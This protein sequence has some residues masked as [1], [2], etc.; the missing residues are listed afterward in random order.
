MNDRSGMVVL[1]VAL[2][3]LLL[4][5][6]MGFL[7]LVGGSSPDCEASLAARNLGAIPDSAAG[8]DREQLTNAGEIIRAG[9]AEG[10]SSRDQTIG[11]MTAIGE[12]TLRVL[13]RG[14]A[15]GPDSRGL[16]QQRDNGAWGSYE[17]RMDPFLSARYFFRALQTVSGRSTMAPTLVAHRVQRNADPQHYALFWNQ[18]QQVF[19]ALTGNA[20][21]PG[22][23][24][25]AGG[26]SSRYKLGPVKHHVAVA[27][28]HIGRM[29]D[30][31]TIG[32]W[33]PGDTYDTEGHPAGLALDLIINSQE[34]GSRI[35]TYAREHAAEMGVKY[36]I[37]YQKIWSPQRDSE[38]WRYM[39]DRGSPSANHLDHVH[40]SFEAEPG[41][42]PLPEGGVPIPEG[43]GD[44]VVIDGQAAAATRGQWVQ[45]APGPITSRYGNRKHPTT[46]VY[47]LHS[48]TDLAG[49]GCDAPIK[50][51]KAGTVVGAGPAAGYGN[52]ITIDHGGRVVTRYAHMY[53]S[54]ILVKTG[55]HV[56]SGQMIGRIGSSGYS[57]GCHLHFEIKIG[58]SFTN[59]QTYLAGYSL[60]IG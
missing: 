39:S 44:T 33:R 25:Q 53:G 20:P 6:P 35:A 56:D 2:A 59:P 5:I 29:F 40:I 34:Q 26:G 31:G 24:P 37:W 8:F 11:I 32:G 21:H 13:D 7:L 60:T 43:C 22:E 36:V 54:G 19:T 55:Q 30:V 46:G 16:F 28:D 58:G 41:T 12:S 27:A 10:V 18:A 15:A 42:A 45:P 3:A 50:A 51:A 47:K 57:T 52:L 17:D 38:G 9:A 14:D 1:G 49:G 4:A 23:A 48:G